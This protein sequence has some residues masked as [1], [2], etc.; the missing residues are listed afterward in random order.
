MSL[1]AIALFVHIVGALALFAMLAV[2]GVSLRTGTSAQGIQQSLGPITA[3][4]IVIPG[5]YMASRIGWQGWAAVGLLSYVVIAG[6]GAYT[7]ISLMRRRMSVSAATISWLA[8]IGITLGVVFD[9]TVKPQILIA[10][11]LVVVTMAAGAALG[12]YVRPKARTA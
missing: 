6:L 1:Y 8:R 5:F 10:A 12:L 2:E 7:G 3:L 9:M 11:I 4:F